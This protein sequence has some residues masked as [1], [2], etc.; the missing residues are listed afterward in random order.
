MD[1]VNDIVSILVCV[2]CNII[3]EEAELEYM[4]TLY[5]ILARFCKTL[6]YCK[7]EMFI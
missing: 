6:F 1:L 4:G 3:V 5:S 2:R 7:V